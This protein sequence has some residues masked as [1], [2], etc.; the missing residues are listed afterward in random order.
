MSQSSP[1]FVPSVIAQARFSA[2]K[3]SK[4][5]LAEGSS[6]SLGLNCFE[7]GQAH[8][9]HAH[10]NADKAYFVVQGQGVFDVAGEE[11]R[12]GEG[13]LIFAPAGI[14][15]GVKNEGPGPLV[16]FVTIAPPIQKKG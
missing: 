14:P 10:A 12:L 6:L 15:H 2:E 1:Y 9:T 8:A 3:M 11:Q 4:C 16:L 5:T 7:P 13:S